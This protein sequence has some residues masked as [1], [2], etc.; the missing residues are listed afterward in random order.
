M[1]E[2]QAGDTVR[3]VR[4]SLLWREAVDIYGSSGAVSGIWIVTDTWPKVWTNS[5]FVGRIVREEDM[6]MN[7]NW[8]RSLSYGEREVESS[9]SV[10]YG[11][12]VRLAVQE[13]VF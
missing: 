8:R 2:F 9:I 6:N 12:V 1:N 10:D 3:I 5:R 7:A 4:N 13:G 11:D